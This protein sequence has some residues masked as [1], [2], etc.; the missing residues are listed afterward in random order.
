M[1]QAARHE[2]FDPWNDLESQLENLRAV[3]PRLVD[4]PSASADQ[5]PEIIRALADAVEGLQRQGIL[6]R[7][8]LASFHEMMEALLRGRD[9]ETVLQTLALYLRM[10]L[11][12]DEV[13]VLRR[14]EGTRPWIGFYAGRDNWAMPIFPDRFDVATPSTPPNASIR[15][16]CSPGDPRRYQTLVPLALSGD[17]EEREEDGPIG[18][19]CYNRSTDWPEGQ[20]SVDEVARRVAGILAT[21]GH[22]EAMERADRFRRQLLEAMKDGVIAARADGTLV[23]LNAASER[24]TGISPE[25]LRGA[26][27]S[28][29]EE[30]A[31]ALASHLSR[32]LAR[33]EV[34]EARELLLGGTEAK[35]PVH[36]GTSAWND[37]AGQLAGLVLNLTDLTAVRAM[38]DE[39]RRLDRLAA[40]GRFAAGVAHE[41]RNPLAGIEAGVEFL[42]RRFAPDGPERED[43]RFV[44]HEVR[45]LNTIV[46]ELLDY[47][48]PKP[49]DPQ[50]VDLQLIADRA[51]RGTLAVAD[52]RQVEVVLAGS[53]PQTIVADP[54]RLEQVVLNLIKNAVEA[55]SS[56]Q[57]VEVSWRA[58]ADSV[59]LAVA[60]R[61]S[62]MSDEDLARSI[63][64]FFTTKGSGTGLGLYLSHAIVQQ[65]GG[66]LRLEN[67]AGGGLLATIEI[68]LLQPER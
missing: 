32:A 24:F 50:K 13:L 18:Y 47:T 41:I 38:E 68:P 7:I 60:D 6:H 26:P 54:N 25:R 58:G 28:A 57:Q 17:L 20:M 2:P 9:A 29:L 42:G 53:E 21:L 51:R 4:C 55:S 12:L 27:L 56:G 1:G 15:L 66:R 67:R 37:D 3:V 44:V 49:L 23:E 64:P 36:I 61:G 40:L 43:L 30:D 10:T 33:R 39:I 8:Q 34:P 19:L 59:S 62:G 45:R 35:L 63:E 14:G 31:P 46:S 16:A 5:A 52:R 48:R 22:R 65:H 11:E